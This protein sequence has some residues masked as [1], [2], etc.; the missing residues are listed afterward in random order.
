MQ[1]YDDDAFDEEEIKLFGARSGTLREFELKEIEQLQIKVLAHIAKL[2][3]I[4]KEPKKLTCFDINGKEIKGNSIKQN[5]EF[6]KAMALYK[7]YLPL[8]DELLDKSTSPKNTSQRIQFAKKV[9]HHFRLAK[10]NFP[11]AL[12]GFNDS[13]KKIVEEFDKIFG[14]LYIHDT[15]YDPKKIRTAGKLE[16]Y[17]FEQDE[18][19][20][21]IPLYLQTGL[22]REMV[23]DSEFQIRL[24]EFA[25]NNKIPM[26]PWFYALYV[27]AKS[28]EVD[29]QKEFQ[30]AIKDLRVHAEQKSESKKIKLSNTNV[31]K[32][33]VNYL[34]K[35]YLS[36]DELPVSNAFQLMGNYLEQLKQSTLTPELKDNISKHLAYILHHF[37]GM[38]KDKD[39]SFLLDQIALLGDK[40]LIEK[41]KSG[42]AK[43]AEE[44]TSLRQIR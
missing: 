36:I 12:S 29:P 10:I 8:L 28:H 20:K 37:D 14:A 13:T 27:E 19:G 23:H 4:D 41:Y 31:L 35:Y 6:H 38:V 22:S 42:Y 24:G 17:E 1:S 39:I 5:L 11:Y 21:I 26:R 30:K 32:S 7:Y 33:A 9:N 18:S 44:I 3:A 34:S 43:D 25:I 16:S 15:N 40:D 2:L